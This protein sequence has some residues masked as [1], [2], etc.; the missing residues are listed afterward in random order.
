MPKLYK[1]YDRRIIVRCSGSL[2]A[3]AKAAAAAQGLTVSE[4]VRESVI[5][6]ILSTDK[7]APRERSGLI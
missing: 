2:E 5:S 3:Q 7:P 6:Q 4:F 1:E